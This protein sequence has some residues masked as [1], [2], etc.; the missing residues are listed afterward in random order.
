MP[1]W[2]QHLARAIHDRRRARG[3]GGDHA[4]A[5]RR[6]VARPR[7]LSVD[8]QLQMGVETV[9]VRRPFALHE[10]EN[11]VGIEGVREDLTVAGQHRAKRP[12]DVA[13]D[14]E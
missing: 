13:E 3:A 14:V 11:L 5:E 7:F 8:Q 10:V 4:G 6:Q 9:D 1:E 2:R 12:I